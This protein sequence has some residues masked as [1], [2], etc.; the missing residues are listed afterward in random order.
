MV[1][2]DAAAPKSLDAGNVAH[3]ALVAEFMSAAFEVLTEEC[4]K[5][6]AIASNA[7]FSGWTKT[8]T[9]PALRVTLIDRL[10]F[11]GSIVETGPDSYRLAHIWH[12]D[13]TS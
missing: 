8:F 1:S 9:A 3:S 6:V 4:K 12:H 10:T 7:S 5:L 2:L 13:D 11:G